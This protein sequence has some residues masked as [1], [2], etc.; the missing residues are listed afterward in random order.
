LFKDRNGNIS[1]RPD[2]CY[3]TPDGKLNIIEV[4]TGNA[5]LSKNQKEV[6]PQIESGE[7]IPFGKN[8]EKFRLGVDEP[9]K[10]R[11]PDGAPVEIK[12]WGCSR[13]AAMLVYHEKDNA[14]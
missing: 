5:K 14:L 10:E 2:I 3:E 8:A 7:A 4:K 9:L 13:L 6:Y 11:Y 12:R 1:C